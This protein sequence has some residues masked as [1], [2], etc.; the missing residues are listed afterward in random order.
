M[1][2]EWHVLSRFCEESLRQA[3][4]CLDTRVLCFSFYWMRRRSHC[5]SLA[6]R[7]P[8]HHQTRDATECANCSCRVF[9][10]LFAFTCL[11]DDNTIQ[12]RYRLKRQTEHTHHR[13]EQNRRN[14]TEPS[15]RRYKLMPQRWLVLFSSHQTFSGCGWL[16]MKLLLWRYKITSLVSFYTLSRLPFFHAYVIIMIYFS[17]CFA[18]LLAKKTILFMSSSSWRPSSSYFFLSLDLIPCVLLSHIFSLW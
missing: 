2:E 17:L 5:L 16:K 3:W 8:L 15:R 6:E 11:I 10:S 12:N 7:D 18:V 9:L 14:S 1:K 4:L 13:I